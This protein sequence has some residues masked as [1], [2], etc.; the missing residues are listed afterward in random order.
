M[1][2][3]IV[4]HLLKIVYLQFFNKRDIPPKFCFFPQKILIFSRILKSSEM[5]NFLVGVENIIGG[6]FFLVALP[7]LMT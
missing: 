6:M 1:V 7:T 2:I 5:L 4:C 3:L